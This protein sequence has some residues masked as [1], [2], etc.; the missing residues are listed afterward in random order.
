MVGALEI[1][2]INL[3]CAYNYYHLHIHNGVVI[4]QIASDNLRAQNPSWRFKYDYSCADI[5]VNSLHC[6]S[7]TSVVVVAD[8]QLTG[9]G[10]CVRDATPPTHSTHAHVHMHNIYFGYGVALAV[11]CCGGHCTGKCL[12]YIMHAL[13]LIQHIL[14]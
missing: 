10:C 14:T 8:N 3:I 1:T 9:S 7:C 5:P 2:A 4:E 11:G 6:N 12:I 13:A